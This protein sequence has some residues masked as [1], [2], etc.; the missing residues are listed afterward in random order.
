MMEKHE[1]DG[2]T[3]LYGANKFRDFTK[4]LDKNPSGA[5]VIFFDVNDLKKYN[6]EIGHHAG[7][8]LLQ[9][10]AE[11]LIAVSD[12]SA[13]PFRLGG[14]EFV[15]VIANCAETDVAVFIKKWR[16]KLAELNK[17]NDGI[18]CEMA[19]GFAFGTGLDKMDAL[20]KLADERMYV[21]K[22]K[23]KEINAQK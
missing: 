14:D 4:M 20:M 10:A 15:V 13:T 17:R 12:D 21:V 23:M 7:D 8:M 19:A 16:G 22:R 2:L 1:R 5:A 3:G 18:H 6:D 9:K 11:S